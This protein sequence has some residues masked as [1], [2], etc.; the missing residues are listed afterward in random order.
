MSN[1]LVGLILMFVNINIGLGA[2]SIDILPDFAGAYLV[3]KGTRE[4]AEESQC[5]RELD[6][7]LKAAI[8]VHALLWGF[9]LFGLADSWGVVSWIFRLA[10]GLLNIYIL[11]QITGGVEELEQLHSVDM[12]SRMLRRWW[13]GIF[14]FSVLNLVLPKWT[15]WTILC[16][17]G[18]FMALLGYLVCFNDGKKAYLAALNDPAVIDTEEEEHHDP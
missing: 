18:W 5:M 4:L 16:V 1:I 2:L 13:I 15:F 14:A 10:A 8:V 11:Y 17:I 6:A 9:Q 12:G 3:W 7:V